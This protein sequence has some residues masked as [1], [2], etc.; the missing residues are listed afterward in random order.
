L[1]TCL[2]RAVAQDTFHLLWM[3]SDGADDLFTHVVFLQRLLSHLNSS[4]V[5]QAACVF[6]IDQVISEFDFFIHQPDFS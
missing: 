6:P 1:A 5:Q 3:S 2:A 4:T